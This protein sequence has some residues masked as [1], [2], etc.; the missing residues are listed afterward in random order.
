MNCISLNKAG[1][2]FW[3]FSCIFYLGCKSND[4]EN[5]T[6]TYNAPGEDVHHVTSPCTSC[7]LN[8]Q[9]DLGE[10]A[11]DVFFIFTNT[12]KKAATPPT[13][14]LSKSDSFEDSSL[15]ME[16]PSEFTDTETFSLVDYAREHGIGLRG[17]PEVTLFN[18][19]NLN[20]SS[21][22]E[23]EKPVLLRRYQVGESFQFKNESVT[24]LVTATLRAQSRVGTLTVNLWVEN[25]SWGSC[26]KRACL[27]Q[28]K[29]NA[30][31]ASFLQSGSNNDIYDWVTNIFGTPWGEHVFPNILIH[32]GAQ[33]TIDILFLD[34][35][36]DNSMSGGVLG[37]FW[38]KD[39]FRAS[40]ISNSNE[41]LI[42][43][44]DS[45]LAAAPSGNGWDITDYWPAEIVST[46]AHELQH[47]IH[48]YQKTILRAN[49]RNS[50]T[51]LNEMTSLA[52]E[53]LI[54]SKIQASGPRGISYQDE[55]SG[56]GYNSSGR[57]PLYNR[58]N[59][60]SLT[61]WG[62]GFTSLR[63]YSVNYSFGAYLARNYKGS[64]FF[65]QLV[66]NKET[67]G[68][69]ITQ[70]LSE[71]GFKDTF[72]SVLSKWTAAV[73]LSDRTEGPTG[74]AFNRGGSF[75]SYLKGVNY[76]IGSINLFNYRYGSLVGPYIYSPVQSNG[77]PAI[78]NTASRIIQMG[79]GLSGMFQRTINLP[80]G[81]QL[82]VVKKLSL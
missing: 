66:Q 54:A 74:Y 3:F 22:L 77:T 27:D 40:N 51:W 25:Q 68:K 48:Y 61:D 9:Q 69:A 35:D 76:S 64:L 13:I 36:H 73:V 43:Y 72:E 7:T 33:N 15:A 19:R 20:F 30:F 4:N 41:R 49:G 18:A 58:Y 5:S 28:E 60:I 63:N 31:Q 8:Y 21:S 37:F 1:I 46:L 39:N 65:R 34:I 80:E 47:M 75:N 52:T 23:I 53:D 71:L 67:D 16:M 59:D 82:T 56:F 70:A 81:I 44:M 62:F 11:V 6:I 79:R 26:Q 10:E 14:H 42:F 12:G 17:K 55:T 29:V 57:L 78:E 50:E 38:S 2:F 45:V 24:D 32:S